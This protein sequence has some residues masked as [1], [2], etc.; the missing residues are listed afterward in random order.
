M[1]L[2][3][4][5]YR[6]FP[7]FL[8]KFLKKYHY[9]RKL[10]NASV[11]DEEDLGLLKYFIKEGDQTFDIGANFGIYSKFM[12]QYCG[13]SGKVFSFEPIKATFNYLCFN[14]KHL[15]YKN[16][17]PLNIAI[18]DFNG[19]IQMEVPKYNNGG[20]N[21]YEAKIVDSISK[22]NKSYSVNTSSLDEIMIEY[23]ASPVFIKCDVEGHELFV[24]KSASKLLST[25]KP[26]LLI[27]INGDLTHPD[28][29]TSELLSI[30]KSE[31]YDI[32]INYNQALKKWNGEKK[33]NYFFLT[34]SHQKNLEEII[35]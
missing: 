26:I 6:F 17:L 10:R 13:P 1:N 28:K 18:S 29:N 3:S 34:A 4:L 2:K 22:E 23:S 20:E 14:M 15:N 25:C 27:E 8:I 11:E 12:S 19:A 21:Y 9:L 7:D 24:F 32:Y 5:G 35:I 30:L 33:T 16:V 31:G